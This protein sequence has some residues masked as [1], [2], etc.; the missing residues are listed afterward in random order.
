MTNSHRIRELTYKAKAEKLQ[1]QIDDM[2]STLKDGTMH[3][4]V[5][6]TIKSMRLKDRLAIIVR[7]LRG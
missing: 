2:Y 6:D 3:Q 4:I 1:R 7:I 5:L